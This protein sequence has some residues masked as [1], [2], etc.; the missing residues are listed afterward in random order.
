MR[1]FG[2][3]QV[4]E[5]I[6]ELFL[7]KM[8]NPCADVKGEHTDSLLCNQLL[9]N[10]HRDSCRPTIA[11]PNFHTAAFCIQKS[12]LIHEFKEKRDPCIKSYPL[13]NRKEICLRI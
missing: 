4:K 13:F 11:K 12:V 9:S 2:T 7:I 10:I 1:I 6:P 3:I 8:S 5:K